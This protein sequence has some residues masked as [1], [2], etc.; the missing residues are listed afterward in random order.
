MTKMNVLLASLNQTSV[1]QA[2]ERLEAEGADAGIEVDFI[3]NT[4][5]TPTDL[6]KSLTGENVDPT[7]LW[8]L[9]LPEESRW[10]FHGEACRRIIDEDDNRPKIYGRTVSLTLRYGANVRDFVMSTNYPTNVVVI[11]SLE[12]APPAVV[13]SAPFSYD[14]YHEYYTEFH[15]EPRCLR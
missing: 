10:D 13:H 3:E 11:L 7:K 12:E 14:P 2:R 5:V 8:I 9:D 15:E 1:R 6:K 4:T